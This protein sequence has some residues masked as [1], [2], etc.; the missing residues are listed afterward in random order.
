MH[1]RSLPARSWEMRWYRQRPREL[2]RDELADLVPFAD[3][4]VVDALHH[5]DARI[6]DD[7]AQLVGCSELVV[8]RRH[9]ERPRW[10]ERQLARCEVHVLRSDPDER[11]RLGPAA[12]REIGEHR[13][14]AEA[15]ADERQREA[16]LDGAGVGDGGCEIVRLIATSAPGPRALADAAEVEAQRV[17]APC[18]ARA[19]YRGHDRRAHRASVRRQGM[20]DHDDRRRIDIRYPQRRLETPVDALWLLAHRSSVEGTAGRRMLYSVATMQPI[21]GLCPPA[22]GLR[23]PASASGSP[24]AAASRSGTGRPSR[25]RRASTSSTRPRARSTT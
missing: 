8:L 4:E 18:R 11:D 14:R 9:D 25:S 10:D 23:P 20:G 16:A 1:P 15:V 7:R 5:G 22:P 13:E 21:G 2:I 3:E 24:D 6:R 12:A 17:P 19:C